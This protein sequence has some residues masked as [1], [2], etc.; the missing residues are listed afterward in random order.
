MSSENLA[1]AKEWV[2][3]NFPN[4]VRTAVFVIPAQAGNQFIQAVWFPACAGMTWL[5]I[6]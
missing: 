4:A 2:R 3:N 6:G 1:T 5:E